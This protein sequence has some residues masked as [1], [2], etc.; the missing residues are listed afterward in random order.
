MPR[1]RQQHRFVRRVASVAAAALLVTV[2]LL[3]RWHEATTIHVRCAAHGELIHVS[4]SEASDGTHHVMGAHELAP[5]SDDVV[6][7]HEHCGLI[8]AV[9]TPVDAQLRLVVTSDGSAH[10]IVRS[11]APIEL[12]ARATFRLAPKTSPPV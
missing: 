3:A 1:I 9:H 2:A 12:I 10:E 11:V 4:H 8:G 7:E 6:G 5:R